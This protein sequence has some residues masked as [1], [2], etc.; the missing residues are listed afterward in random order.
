M[1]KAEKKIWHRSYPLRHG[2]KR[3][4]AQPLSVGDN[5]YDCM[6]GIKILSPRGSL[7]CS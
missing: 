7:M 4:A 3:M 6:G 5:K 1:A 2:I